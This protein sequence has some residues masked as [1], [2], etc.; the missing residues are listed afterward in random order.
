[1]FKNAKY[2]LLIGGL[3]FSLLT[4][5][6]KIEAID[7]THLHLDVQFEPEQR[8][9]NGKVKLQF[10]Y[11]SEVDSIYLN[12]VKMEYHKVKLNKKKAK[13]RF[14]KKGIWL[15]AK[16]ARLNEINQIE[17]EYSCSPRKGLY[18]IGWNDPKGIS[19]KQI[20]T[21]GQGIDNRHWIPHRD[22][23][24]DKL[25]TEIEV[26]FN[27]E[28]EVISNGK[29]IEKKEIGKLF[30]WHYKL[31]KPHS[32]Y[33]IMLAVGKYSKKETQSITGIPLTQYYYP[34][35][36]KDYDYYYLGNEKIFD[37]MEAEVGVPY[38]WES[39]CQ[40]PVMNFRHGAMENTSATIFG[41]FFMVDSI[42]FNDKNYTYVNAHELAHQ[43]FGN[44]VT[45]KNSKHHWLHE[46]F[47]TYYQWLSEKNIY[48]QDF[49]D[50]MRYKE[51][52]LVFQATESD[53]TP[54]GNEKAGSSRFYQKGAWVL[55]ML[56]Q[57]L[58]DAN[59]K[60]II[61]DYLK[62]N[63]FGL[64]DTE[65]LDASVVK[66]IGKSASDYF[67]R[68]IY[69][70]DEPFVN[71]KSELRNDTLFFEVI[72]QGRT[73][74]YFSDY[75]LPLKVVFEDGTVGN[76]FIPIRKEKYTNSQVFNPKKKIKYWVVNP[77]MGIL[78]NL[79]IETP[80]SFAVN[81]Y[82]ACENVLDRYFAL[83]SISKVSLDEKKDFLIDVLSDK[84]E[85]HS[86]RTEALSQLLMDNENRVKYMQIA[87]QSKDIQLQKEAVNM[88]SFL[89]DELRKDAFEL[90]YAS[91]YQLRETISELL[92]DPEDKKLNEW[93][94]T[95]NIEDQP[96]IPGRNLEIK[97][98][99]YRLLFFQKRKAL[100]ELK[101]RTSASYD[102]M[103]RMNAIS[104]LQAIGYLDE[105]L[106][107]YYFD[108]LFDYNWKLVRKA[109]EALKAGYETENGKSLILKY[110]ET[111][112]DLWN[113][114]QNRTANRT[115]DLK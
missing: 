93:L 31:N 87:F 70:P 25:I 95:Y 16:A 90:Q 77:D 32:S 75:S 107:D 78:A 114:S 101:E 81:Q 88:L 24:T 9:V 47:A 7:F 53:S 73:S 71:L 68:W 61:K 2:I 19:K 98:L 82:H 105:G 21:Q 28:Y 20:W 34:E 63:S 4:F 103:T 60:L 113:D 46:G 109:R 65:T 43:W 104:A 69:N 26:S 79:E 49:F 94:L 51:A 29:L 13:Y 64:V 50:W 22:E 48:G 59:F 41:D 91:S 84:N 33:L 100:V 15:S 58:G 72:Q 86:L 80:F 56:H 10:N 17:I 38:P 112:K 14:D 115:F 1:M 44:L 36:K 106:L 54:L 99:L 96:G 40:V 102:F 92:L 67:K 57:N 110:V 52:K 83:K 62:T 11:N 42:A 37:F 85:F 35:R 12:G 108:G 55:Y 97:V 30:K 45:A 23:Q 8:Q 27:K 76:T 111:H 18:F 3:F 89:D 74:T 66:V 39:Y 6:Q 5:S